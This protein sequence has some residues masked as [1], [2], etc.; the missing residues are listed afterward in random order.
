MTTYQYNSRIFR[1]KRLEEPHLYQ[2]PCFDV[3]AVIE[4]NTNSTTTID[5]GKSLA[6]RSKSKL[7]LIDRIYQKFK[8][9]F[10][11]SQTISANDTIQESEYQNLHIEPPFS[12]KRSYSIQTESESL[13][14]NL[15]SVKS[16]ASRVSGKKR[17]F[18]SYSGDEDEDEVKTCEELQL[19]NQKSS[20]SKR[21]E[22]ITRKDSSV[23]LVQAD[24]ASLT[25][26]AISTNKKRYFS[27]Y[28]DNSDENRI[29]RLRELETIFSNNK[30]D[31]DSEEKIAH[32]QGKKLKVSTNKNDS[33]GEE[34]VSIGKFSTKLSSKLHRSNSNKPKQVFIIREEIF[35]EKQAVEA[36]STKQNE[37]KDENQFDRGSVYSEE[38][39]SC[40]N[41]QQEREN[42]YEV[43]SSNFGR[44]PSESESPENSLFPNFFSPVKSTQQ[45]PPSTTISKAD[46]SA[47]E[48]SNESTPEKKVPTNIQLE[49][50][51]TVLF[52]SLETN[53]PAKDESV[54]MASKE[55]NNQPVVEKKTINENLTIQPALFSNNQV[56]II[57]KAQDTIIS[58]TQVTNTSQE[59]V[60]NNSSSLPL[61]SSVNNESQQKETLPVSNPVLQSSLEKTNDFLKDLQSNP[62]LI[63]TSSSVSISNNPFVSS[64]SGSTTQNTSNSPKFS[65]ESII[66]Q[67]PSSSLL[68]N[69]TQ[70]TS[71]PGM[72]SNIG[73]SNTTSQMNQ[74]SP[75]DNLFNGGLNRNNS[76]SFPFE[77]NSN[78]SINSGLNSIMGN[79]NN[80]QNSSLPWLNQNS[81]STNNMLGGLI[82]SNGLS[83]VSNPLGRNDMQSE[84]MGISQNQGGLSLGSLGNFNQ[85]SIGNNFN[86]G[87]TNHLNNL[88]N[89]NLQS[90]QNNGIN[91]ILGGAGVGCMNNGISNSNS[92]LQGIS[93]NTNGP[94]GSIFEST[95]G[96]NFNTSNSAMNNI[97]QSNNVAN[98]NIFNNGSMQGSGISQF[99]STQNYSNSTGGDL[100][101]GNNNTNSASNNAFLQAAAPTQRHYKVLKGIKPQPGMR[102]SDLF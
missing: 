6:T 30:M 23:R 101:S 33:A 39:Q 28:K 3:R 65:L 62:F 64:N 73:Q 93:Q 100:F 68:S 59:Q 56:N 89:G 90:N 72:F 66:S 49:V 42:Q 18:I 79:T 1:G 48:N 13:S 2:Y 5:D 102:M 25:N 57:P 35:A 51:P 22:K 71:M 41:H 27:D 32:I 83:N 78:N 31:L 17:T 54:V 53:Q 94:S 20:E 74:L 98:S 34:R 80:Q 37:K 88:F 63:S 81:G 21:D 12:L 61:S 7:G 55:D 77:L 91:S 44:V 96:S 11:S 47:S 9:V 24:Q 86:Q 4:T 99:N 85:G 36:S 16:S 82:N 50:K 14:S 58:Q 76:Q 40:S 52:S 92:F 67:N 46:T 60:A 87:S 26:S 38:T 15:Q 43:Y 69:T 10:H 29:N 75:L 8:G 95:L 70:N 84:S 97:Y 19:K 45:V